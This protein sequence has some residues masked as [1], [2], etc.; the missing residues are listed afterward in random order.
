MLLPGRRCAESLAHPRAG[1]GPGSRSQQKRVVRSVQRHIRCR[2]HLVLE[3]Q[4]YVQEPRSGGRLG[5]DA[6]MGSMPRFD[7]LGGVQ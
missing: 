7:G 3:A 6:D 2:V 1:A 4:Q 5:G